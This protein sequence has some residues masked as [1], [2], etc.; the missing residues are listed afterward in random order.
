MLSHQHLTLLII[1]TPNI[2][3]ITYCQIPMNALMGATIATPTP[4]APTLKAP[5]T[6]RVTWATLEMESRVL[7]KLFPHYPI[8]CITSTPDPRIIIKVVHLE[9]ETARTLYYYNYDHDHD[10]DYD[11]DD[12]D[13]DDDRLLWK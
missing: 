12:D 9:L 10:Y 3:F 4:P 5:L 13:D 8:D 1:N 6:A 7:V 11:D 2:L